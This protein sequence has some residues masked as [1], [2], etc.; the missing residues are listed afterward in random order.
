M[1]SSSFGKWVGHNLLFSDVLESDS[2]SPCT[3]FSIPDYFLK[4]FHMEGGGNKFGLLAPQ[5]EFWIALVAS[6]IMGALFSSCL[7]CIIYHF[8]VLPRKEINTQKRK[9]NLE[10]MTPFIVGFGI[11]MPIC[12]VSPYYGLRYFMI[13]NKILKF[14]TGVAQITS[15]FRCSEAMFGFLPSNV[16]DSLTQLITYTA[17][18]VEV[19]FDSKGTVK[20][21]WIDVKYYLIN[22]IKY[23]VILG[24]YSSILLAYDYQPYPNEEG[25]A[26]QDIKLLNGFSRQQLINNLSVAIMFQ[27]YL[28][29][30]GFGINFLASLCGFQLTPFMLNPMFESSSPSDFWGKRWNLVMHGMLK[31]GVYK[32]VRT[33][34]SRLAASMATF[35]A[36]GVFHEWLLSVMF[37]PDSEDGT[38]SPI[39]YHPGYGRNTLFFV[40]NAIVIGL[41]YA[42]GGAAIFQLFHKHLPLTVVSLMV[43]STALPAA[44]W[45]TNDYVRSDF[46]KD[47]QIGFPLII[48]M[49]D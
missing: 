14:F 43:A 29:T 40:W 4:L 35:I 30:F 21:T 41:E 33:K 17:F 25:P 2:R 46:F 38:C 26:M 5:I 36:S 45:F 16:D 19:K 15:F 18:P 49:S 31:R 44:H 39:C 13:K 47:G 34:Y 32:P 22:W 23:I 8:I 20:S 24:M 9:K 6:L 42:I 7:S 3:T 11:V 48:R 37:Y 10:S 27:V 1:S 28:T 12:I